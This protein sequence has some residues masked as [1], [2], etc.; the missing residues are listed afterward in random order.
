V[1]ARDDFAALDPAPLGTVTLGEGPGAVTVTVK[2]LKVGKLPAFAR[3]LQP[4]SGEISAAMA[5]G[6]TVDSVLGLVH[7]HFDRVIEALAVAT[8]ASEAAIRDATIDQALE[9]VLAVLQANKDFL[10]GR[11]V[12]ALKTAAM[13]NPGAGKTP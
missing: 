1:S 6:L 11:L 5:A 12:A 4:L 8:D 13:V 10:R 2:A 9:L 3:A 7:E